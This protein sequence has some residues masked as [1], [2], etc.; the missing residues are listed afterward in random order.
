M[1]SYLE[2]VGPQAMYRETNAWKD[3]S[4]TAEQSASIVMLISLHTFELG[5]K[6]RPTGLPPRN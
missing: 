2:N 3:F 6:T 4:E 5:S 1:S